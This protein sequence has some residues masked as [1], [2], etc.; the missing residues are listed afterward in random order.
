MLIPIRHGSGI[1]VKAAEC[2]YHGMPILST[3][4]GL[5]GL[6]PMEHPKIVRRET[7]QECAS[8]LSSQEARTGRDDRLPHRISRHFDLETNLPRCLEFLS[9]VLPQ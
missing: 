6:P 9:R 5:R 8:F 4:F 3:S 2:L 7:S 1:S